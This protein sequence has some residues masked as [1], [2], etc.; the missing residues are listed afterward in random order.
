MQ[1]PIHAMLSKVCND[2]SCQ[3]WLTLDAGFAKYYVKI[4]LEGFGSWPYE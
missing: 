2:S 1:G 3:I 4:S